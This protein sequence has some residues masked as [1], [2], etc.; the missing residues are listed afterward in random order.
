MVPYCYL[1]LLSVFILWFSYYVSDLFGK[2]LFIRFTTSAF[3]K[4]PS[5]YV[6]SY[7]PFGFGGRIWDTIVSV[8]DHYLSFNFAYQSSCGCAVWWP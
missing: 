2:E 3:C 1:F 5:N 8:P 4:L 6:F 7:F